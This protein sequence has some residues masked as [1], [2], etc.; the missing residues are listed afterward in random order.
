MRVHAASLNPIDLVMRTG[1]G[2]SVFEACRASAGTQ[3]GRASEPEPT[4]GS[5]FPFVLGRDLSGVVVAV[6]SGV[7]DFRVGDEVV[8]ATYPFQPGSFAGFSAS[9]LV[10]VMPGAD[11]WF[12]LIEPQT[13]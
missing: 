2:R 9:S 13:L 12:L 5:A 11:C 7:W 4:N 3:G 6:G 1:Y 8:A 10:S